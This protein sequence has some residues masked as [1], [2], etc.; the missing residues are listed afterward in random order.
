MN[1]PNPTDTRAVTASP[2]VAKTKS[3]TNDT[4]LELEHLPFGGDDDAW[5]L[6]RNDELV[7]VVW[8]SALDEAKRRAAGTRLITANG[9]LLTLIHRHCEVLARE[10]FG[11]QAYALTE[12]RRNPENGR[13]EMVVEVHYGYADDDLDMDDVAAKHE[14]F[15]DRY[16]ESIPGPIRAQLALS[17]VVVDADRT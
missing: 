16:L 13:D 1:K 6:T 4:V 3:G 5:A 11:D 2:Q 17:S 14:Q 8:S 15:Y 12:P 7:G 10:I 9:P